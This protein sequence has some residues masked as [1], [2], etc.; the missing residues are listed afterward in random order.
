MSYLTGRWSEDTSD[1]CFTAYL[2]DFLYHNEIFLQLRWNLPMNKKVFL[3]FLAMNST[4]LLST[5]QLTN[6]ISTQG[7]THEIVWEKVIFMVY[8]GRKKESGFYFIVVTPFLCVK[9][10][11]KGFS[12]LCFNGYIFS[13]FNFWPWGSKDWRYREK[14][15][16][17]PHCD[18]INYTS[19]QVLI[20]AFH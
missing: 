2:G 13:F 7:L 3:F 16:D 14:S 17:F 20:L 4:S 12:V 8:I 10:K 1:K 5:S 15:L 18:H 6:N 19:L 9:V 11:Q